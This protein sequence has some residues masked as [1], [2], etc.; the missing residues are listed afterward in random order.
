M[1]KKILSSVFKKD[2]L[3]K[4]RFLLTIIVILIVLFRFLNIIS[5]RTSFVLLTP[6]FIFSV[7]CFNKLK[8]N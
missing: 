5:L 6:I 7:Y 4:T 2:W 8:N 3:L 1:N